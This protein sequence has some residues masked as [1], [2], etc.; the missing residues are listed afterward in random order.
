MHSQA[1]A[2]A[3]AHALALPVEVLEVELVFPGFSR[4]AGSA[5]AAAAVLA[6]LGALLRVE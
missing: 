2:D 6:L 3:L 4:A 1:L 5:T